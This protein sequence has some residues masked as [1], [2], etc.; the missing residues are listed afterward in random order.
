MNPGSTLAARSCHD[1]ELWNEKNA[2]RSRREPKQRHPSERR[3]A[4]LPFPR[5]HSLRKTRPLGLPYKS[6]QGF[7]SGS[8]EAHLERRGA[9]ARTKSRIQSLRGYKSPCGV[10]AAASTAKDPGDKDCLMQEGRNLGCGILRFMG[11]FPT[12]TRA[13]SESKRRGGRRRSFTWDGPSDGPFLA[14]IAWQGPGC[15]SRDEPKTRIP[16]KIGQPRPC[17]NTYM[18]AVCRISRIRV[19]RVGRIGRIASSAPVSAINTAAATRNT[20]S[21]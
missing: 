10:R 21:R 15:P 2:V 13:I 19:R 9:A 1:C 11:T 18:P 4:T 5:Q 6:Y 12:R 3:P 16:A 17:K 20:G 7:T 8:L 14:G